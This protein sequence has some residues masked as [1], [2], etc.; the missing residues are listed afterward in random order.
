[1][2]RLDFAK[3]VTAQWAPDGSRVILN[4]LH[5]DS[6]YTAHS[7]EPEDVARVTHLTL[8]GLLA[9]DVWGMGFLSDERLALLFLAEAHADI[10]AATPTG[11]TM[12]NLGHFSAPPGW[13]VNSVRLAGGRALVGTYASEPDA[14]GQV[15]YAFD[16]RAVGDRGAPSLAA[17]SSPRLAI[18]ADLSGTLSIGPRSGGPVLA[19]GPGL[20]CQRR[21]LARIEDGGEYPLFFFSA[22][23][24]RAF[25]SQKRAGHATVRQN[26]V[27]LRGGAT[28]TFELD[29]TE[30]AEA[31]SAAFSADSSVLGYLIRR[32]GLTTLQVTDVSG[33]SPSA[34]VS[35][36]AIEE[37][38]TWAWPPSAE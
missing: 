20:S 14:S 11:S 7:I 9:T 23:G 37:I 38:H 15:E 4:A 1:M 17:A 30:A 10:F 19:Y 33:T 27:D 22:D 28:R 26:Y 8:P 13:R 29:V 25:F 6:S 16:A 36:T 12:T 35:V 34:P 31:Q 21:A 32:G 18:A 3:W 2:Q 5:L 24:T